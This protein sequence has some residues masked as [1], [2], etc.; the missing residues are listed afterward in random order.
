MTF[1]APLNGAHTYSSAVA[2][3]VSPQSPPSTVIG[4]LGDTNC[5][6]TNQWVVSYGP[7][8]DGCLPTDIGIPGGTTPSAIPPSDWTGIWT[9]PIPPYVSFFP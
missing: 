7:S 9:D 1:T 5:D 6:G 8:I 4:P 3:P 2:V